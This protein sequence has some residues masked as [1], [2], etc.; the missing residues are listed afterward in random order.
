MKNRIYSFLT[1]GAVVMAT[2]LL[3]FSCAKYGTGPTGGPQDVAPPRLVKSLPANGKTRFAQQKIYLGFDEY[4][5]LNSTEKIVVSP[6][7]KQ[8][9][10][11]SNLK[12]VIVSI[13]DTLSPDM[14]YSINFK[15]AIGDFHESTPIRD[16][17]F[18]FSTGETIDSGRVSGKVVDALEHK[19]VQDAKVLLYADKP[20]TYPVSEAPDY[21]ATTDAEGIFHAQYMKEG[22]YYVLVTTDENMNYRVDPTEEKMAFSDRCF[23]TRKVYDPVM[24]RK[25]PGQKESDL[26]AKAWY[27]SVWNLQKTQLASEIESLGQVLYQY[28]DRVDSVFLKEA[29]SSKPGL[30]ELTWHYPLITDSLRFH[31]LPSENDVELARLFDQENSGSGQDKPE[32]DA[33]RKE[34]GRRNS[35]SEQEMVR[36][37]LDWPDSVRLVYVPSPDLLSG[38]IFFD[39]MGVASYR[40]VTEYRRFS[41]TSELMFDEGMIGKDTLRF[42]MT[43]RPGTVFFQDSIYMAFSLPIDSFGFTTLEMQQVFTDDEGVSDTLAIPSEDI[44]IQRV[45]SMGFVMR[46][47]WKPGANYGVMMPSACVKDWFGRHIDT[48]RF[49]FSVPSL[50][51]YGQLG[52]DLQGLDSSSVYVLQLMSGTNVV[53]QVRVTSCGWVDFPYLSPGRYTVLLF[54]DFNDNGRWDVGYYPEN[55]LPEPRWFFGKELQVEADWRIEEKWT[56]GI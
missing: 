33:P 11:E 42:S 12:D 17:T 26:A 6:L 49:N 21:V 44:H 40:L 52:I 25:K 30:V 20:Q 15:D 9:S 54:K 47:D 27:D 2:L 14:T 56:L 34:K 29:K 4:V 50:D 53:E 10:Y 31:F 46:Y 35:R 51:T 22:C 16:Y 39:N 32:E 13:T 41:D 48:T 36:P 19:P 55:L 37:N 18:V 7:L 38:K 1:I 3:M 24:F 5:S 23:P 45:D 8:V 28:Q 43:D